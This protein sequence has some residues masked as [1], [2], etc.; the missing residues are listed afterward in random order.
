M[1]V[2]HAD[3]KFPRLFEL[4]KEHRALVLLLMHSYYGS[5]QLVYMDYKRSADTITFNM[6]GDGMSEKPKTFKTSDVWKV[7]NVAKDEV[8]L[9]RTRQDILDEARIYEQTQRRNIGRK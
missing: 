7:W 8:Y 6:A 3:I 2:P 1:H 9:Q 4:W 5:E